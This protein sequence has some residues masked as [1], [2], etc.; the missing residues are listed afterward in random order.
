MSLTPAVETKTIS[1]AI[2]HNLVP[3]P[4]RSVSSIISQS[5]AARL[6]S[7]K[8]FESFH[9]G[10]TKRISFSNTEAPITHLHAKLLLRKNKEENIFLFEIPTQR[11]KSNEE[12]CARKLILKLKMQF[13]Y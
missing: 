12:E 2:I 11:R 1:L 7:V 8:P 5:V 3:F 6:I 13:C 9:F 4:L 10:A